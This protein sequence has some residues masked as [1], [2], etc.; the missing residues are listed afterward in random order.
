MTMISNLPD[1]IFLC[2]FMG[3]GKSVIGR[4]LAKVL[5]VSFLDRKSVV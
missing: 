5:E 1:R 2:G 4:K 3:A